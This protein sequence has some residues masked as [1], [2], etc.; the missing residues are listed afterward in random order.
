MIRKLSILIFCTLVCTWQYVVIVLAPCPDCNA[1]MADIAHGNTHSP[2]SYRLLTPFIIMAMGNT[3]QA[4]AIFH[5]IMFALFFALLWQWAASWHV[6]PL[7][8]MALAT[9][10][11]VVML[12][13]YWQAAYAITENVIWLAGLLLLQPSAVMGEQKHE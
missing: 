12:Q 1:F 7:L 2:F 3:P 9:I 6:D 11:M 4:L 8:P 13:T 5:L 10:A